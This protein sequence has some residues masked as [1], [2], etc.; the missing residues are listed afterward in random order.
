MLLKFCRESSVSFTCQLVAGEWRL[1]ICLAVGVIKNKTKKTTQQ[2]SRQI[3]LSIVSTRG[4]ISPRQRHPTKWMRTWRENEKK[5]KTILILDGP[6]PASR[7]SSVCGDVPSSPTCLLLDG[8]LEKM[9]NKVTN[10]LLSFLPLYQ[11][12]LFLF[13]ILPILLSLR[14]IKS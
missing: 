4:R 6:G 14:L 1:E 5:G 9:S 2:W 8:S 12:I 11:V 13:P 10:L 3:I 7:L